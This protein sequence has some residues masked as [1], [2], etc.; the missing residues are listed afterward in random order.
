MAYKDIEKRRA[1]GRRQYWRH[2]DAHIERNRKYKLENGDLV[3][4]QLAKSRYGF[5]THAEYLLARERPCEICGKHSKKMCID[6]CG[7]PHKFNG[8]HRGTLCQQ[9]NSRLG[10]FER[11]MNT[12]HNYITVGGYS[13]A[14]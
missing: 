9:C 2:R 3:R 11:N 4:S 6:H 13:Y 7:D 12:I 10:W 1:N 5:E 14:S 8:T